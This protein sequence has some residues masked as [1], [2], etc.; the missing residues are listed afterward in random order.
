MASGKI[1]NGVTIMDGSMGRELIFSGV[2]EDTNVWSGRALMEEKYHQTVVD[3]HKKYIKA[4]ASSITTCNYPVQP[5]YYSRVYGNGP[6]LSQKIVEHTRIAAQL[7]VKA[8][9]DL[10]S[11]VVI[12][13]SL[14]PMLETFR[15][16]LINEYLE[17]PGNHGHAT[18]YYQMIAKTL[19][20][21]VDVFHLETM[22]NWAEAECALEALKGFD[23]P[24]WIFVGG[25]L[26]DPSTLR[27]RP[28]LALDFARK[29]LKLIRDEGLKISLI[30]FNCAPPE[31]IT[32]AL[33]A[34]PQ[35]LK[36][37]LKRFGVGMGAYANPIDPKCLEK[38]D[39]SELNEGGEVPKTTYRKDITP[40][41]YLNHVD[42]WHKLGVTHVGG[43]CGMGPLFIQSL[44]NKF[45]S[46]K[47]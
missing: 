14:P 44:S 40:K 22:N 7:A 30:G 46:A 2:P 1:I 42:K 21:Y 25:R 12:A 13:G 45:A 35:S 37:E 32:E 31:D 43:C 36:D 4:G 29:C 11:K 23:K 24:I 15:P 41:S 47:L 27:P 19:S 33:R 16:D 3:V 38:Y 6:E 5:R 28:E 9:D 34:I 17:Q 10:N 39:M 18:A 20:D 8:R 26:P